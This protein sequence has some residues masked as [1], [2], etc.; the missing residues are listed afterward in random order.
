MRVCA[1][2]ALLLLSA[3][4]RSAEPAFEEGDVLALAD[5]AK[6]SPY[7]PPEFW[8]H[9]ELF[10]YEGMQLEIGP[11]QRLRRRCFGGEAPLV[12]RLEGRRGA[13]RSARRERRDRERCDRQRDA[14]RLLGR[15]R[16]P[17]PAD[18]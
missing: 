8:A 12:C 3:S 18:A 2:A 4:A 5:V 9:R 17:F 10:F 7:L 1:L 13:A 11:T 16:N 6:L 14:A 15:S